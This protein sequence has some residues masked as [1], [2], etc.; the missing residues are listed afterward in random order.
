MSH[1]PGS[2]EWKYYMMRHIHKI[3]STNIKDSYKGIFTG[4]FLLKDEVLQEI[5]ELWT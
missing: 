5:R 3:V 4:L 1:Q 2:Y